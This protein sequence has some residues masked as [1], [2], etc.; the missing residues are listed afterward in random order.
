[1]AESGD[2]NETMN[3]L[4]ERLNKSKYYQIAKN[5]FTQDRERLMKFLSTYG[6]YIIL[7]TALICGIIIYFKYFYCRV[8]RY[9]KKM[10]A[11]DEILK[12]QPL[13]SCKSFQSNKNNNSKDDYVLCDYYIAS[14]YK[15]Y[16]PCTNYYDYGDIRSVEKVLRYGARY[17]D[18]D[19]YNKD[20]DLCTEP[21]I[22][23]GTEKGNWKWTTPILFEDCIKMISK[24]AFS[25]ELA[26]RND[27]LFINLNLYT[28]GNKNTIN[29]IYKSI[30]DH[31]GHKLLPR[32]YNFQGYS[33]NPENSVDLITTPIKK[34]FDK[35][36][37]IC[38]DHFKGTKLDEIVHLSAKSN[39]NFRNLNYLQVKESHEPNELKNFNKKHM[40]RII[41]HF[42]NR[43]KENY[44]YAT[45]WYL[46]CQFICMNYTHVDDIMTE[47]IRRFKKCSFVLK[48]YKLRYHAKYIPAPKKQL[49]QVSFAPEKVSTPFYSITY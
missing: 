14:S 29:K 1:M 37:I 43:T 48:P 34:L 12:I 18:L 28:N 41:P 2:I 46:G 5:R 24:V 21:V 33:P 26:N 8:E 45:P 17:I 4:K 11:F 25:S 13:S 40:T 47:Y 15:S 32:K 7:S 30:V 27:P 23:N 9:L 19:I 10:N 42:N 44:N 3:K 16:L 39:G 22:S 20:F 6:I 35:V 49:K 31:L 38:D 36:I